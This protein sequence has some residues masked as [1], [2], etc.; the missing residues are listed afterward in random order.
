MDQHKSDNKK[1]KRIFSIGLCLISIMLIF[2]VY[3][4][5][6]KQYNNIID[7]FLILESQIIQEAAQMANLWLNKRINEEG[8]T[9]EQ[10]EQEI[11]I[12]IIEPISLLTSGDAWIYNKDYVIF[13]KS[14][15]FPDHYRG[16]SMRQI[17]E[18][19]SQYGASHYEEILLGVENATEGRGWYIWLPE[20]GKERVAWTS[21]S[22]Y[23]QTWTLGLS[24]PEKEILS[25]GGLY[26]FL[27]KQI[28]YF[29]IITVLLIII[30][31]QFLV[32]QERQR[33]LITELNQLNRDLK[34]IDEMKNNFIANI[35]HDFKTPLSIIY[36]VAELNLTNC[37][38]GTP[39]EVI[40]DFKIIHSTSH[41]F[42]A[43]IN[44]LID[45]IKLETHGLPLK[46]L[47]IDI[48]EFLSGIAQYYEQSLRKSGIEVSFEQNLVG[49]SLFYTDAG[50]LEDII[51][52]LMF[53]AIKFIKHDDGKINIELSGN[54]KSIQI[55]IQ[56]NGIGLEEGDLKKIFTRFESIEMPSK[57][58]YKGSGI[59]LTY[60]EQ[61]AALIGGNIKVES[62]G[63]NKGASF[64]ISLDR[65]KFSKNDLDSSEDSRHYIPNRAIV[66][67]YHTESNKPKVSITATNR[68]FEF[69]KFKGIILIVED[70][71]AIRNLIVRFLENCGYKNFI[72]ADNG[73]TAAEMLQMYQPDLIIT[74]YKMP[75]MNGAEFYKIVRGNP[76]FDFIPV[77]FLSAVSDN[78]TILEQKNQ[79]AVDYLTKPINKEELLVSVNTN[80][81]KYMDFIEASSV[82]ELT[83][84]FNRKAFFRNCENI[85]LNPATSDFSLMII[86]LD[87]F[88]RV[89]DIY[90]HQGGDYILSQISLHILE[91]I[92]NQD[93]AGRY[94]GEE[95]V[96]LLPETNL[97]QSKIV[98]EKIRKRISEL[99]INYNGEIIK[100]TLSIGIATFQQCREDLRNLKN[101]IN[102]SEKIVEMADTALYYAKNISCI[103]CGYI[104]KENNTESQ[105]CPR[106]GLPLKGSRNRVEEFN[107]KMGI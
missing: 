32:S 2:I 80:M 77:I 70:E 58:I 37:E 104:D 84:F 62:K 26:P 86:D 63:R 51:N 61:L 92:R 91:T 103:H 14:S 27:V 105:S 43:K 88:K 57:V 40:E 76:K 30:A 25:Y 29:L 82:D 50:K 97:V 65:E 100:K 35:S 53:N 20:K 59:G 7:N 68:Q 71:P 89:N 22:F 39:Q 73:K 1:L 52:N 81:K 12:N 31:R 4:I 107:D 101:P 36:N 79:G 93:I 48:H 18:I 96:V 6:K 83:K 49:S 8:A 74:D 44:S 90:G 85:I 46:I 45:L 78:E 95:F 3:N 21:F 5:S 64:T 42:I 72:T 106:C 60:S 56:D 38:E 33:K 10:I 16:K 75:E 94:G 54:G 15:D 28:V 66:D 69:D 67:S 13:D 11:L 99:E 102:L 47:E 34:N 9:I 23:N 24:T 17:F 19:Q 98:A 41:R 55:K 87:H